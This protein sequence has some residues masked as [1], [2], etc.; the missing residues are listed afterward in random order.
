MKALKLPMDE[1]DLIAQHT[2]FFRSAF[3]VVQ[4]EIEFEQAKEM[5][6]VY[7]SKLKV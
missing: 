4:E 7:L 3:Q 1:E 2:Q 6:E 5:E